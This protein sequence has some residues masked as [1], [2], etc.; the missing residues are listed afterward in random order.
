MCM[1][2]KV[3]SAYEGRMNSCDVA[4]NGVEDIHW[5]FETHA[6]FGEEN[7]VRLALVAGSVPVH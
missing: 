5:E 3:H 6:H 7:E 1:S 4:V 2:H